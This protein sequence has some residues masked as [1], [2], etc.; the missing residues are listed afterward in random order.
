[1]VSVFRVPKLGLTAEEVTIAKWLKNPGDPVTAGEPFVVVETDKAALDVEAPGDGFLS[2]QRVEEGGVIAVGAELAVFVSSR[3][4]VGQGA[5]APVPTAAE[6]PPGPAQPA[7]PAGAASVPDALA[8]GAERHRASPAVRRRA[9]RQ[10]IDL[11]AIRGTGP[12]GRIR[13]QDLDLAAGAAEAPAL[14][15]PGAAHIEAMGRVRRTTAQRMLESAQAIPQFTLRREVD[16]ETV[17][18]LRQILRESFLRSDAPLSLMDFLIQA[19]ADA[20]IRHPALRSQLAGPLSDGRIAVREGA[21]IGMAVA[22]PEGLLV[23]VI[24]GAHELSLVEIARAR[25]ACVDAAKT[26]RLPARFAGQGCFTISNLGPY[27]VD[28]FHALVN[29]GEAAI[30][31]VGRVRRVP[32]ENDGAIALRPRMVLT[33]TFDHRLVDGAEGAQFAK[34]LVEKFE[35]RDWRLV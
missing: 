32:A 27:D 22:A 17:L 33:F 18:E 30:V 35:S 9:M 28:E 8:P 26:G 16:V 24:A 13:M 11:G 29:P 6:E 4:E 23:P 12:N 25:R 10:G 21:D 15:T 14:R 3:D 20:L 31:A 2:A 19:S 1:M 7:V 34:D 5:Q